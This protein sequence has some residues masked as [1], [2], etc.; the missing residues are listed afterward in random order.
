MKLDKYPFSHNFYDA[1]PKEHIQILERFDG[2]ILY[3]NSSHS[4]QIPKFNSGK[5][6]EIP[7]P[8][9][10]CSDATHLIDLEDGRCIAYVF[11]FRKSECLIL[12]GK[13]TLDRNQL[14]N[15]IVIAQSIPELFERIFEVQGQY[16]FDDSNFVWES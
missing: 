8:N 6:Y 13:Q 3:A 11:N 5:T 14:Q 15:P 7:E 2:A 12:L 9:S 16:Y 1:V 4:W 10:F